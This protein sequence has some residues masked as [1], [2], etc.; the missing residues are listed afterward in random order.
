[1]SHSVFDLLTRRLGIDAFR[2]LFQ[3]ILTDNG[4]EFQNPVRLESTEDVEM[5]TKIYFCNPNKLSF[6]L[7]NNKLNKVPHLEEIPPDEVPL[8]PDLLKK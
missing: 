5:R 2:E 3:V 7:L 8:C 6:M 4:T 1:M